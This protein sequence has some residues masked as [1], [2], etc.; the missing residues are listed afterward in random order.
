MGEA[1]P[2][3]RHAAPPERDVRAGHRRCGVRRVSLLP[4]VEETRRRRFGARQFQCILRSFLET[5]PTEALG[6]APDL[7]RRG[8]PQ[9]RTIAL[10]AI[11]HCPLHPYPSPRGAGRRALRNAE[12]SLVRQFQHRRIREPSGSGQER[13]PSARDCLGIV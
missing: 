1:G 11:R 8:R 2:A 4:G 6:K 12:P 3:L 10:Q 13:R 5:R 9:R 7:H